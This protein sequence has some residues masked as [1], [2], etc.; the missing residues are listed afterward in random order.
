M[1][2][3]VKRGAFTLIEMVFV[4]VILGIVGMIGSDIIAKMYQGYLKSQIVNKLQQQ[5][6]LVLDIIS[7]RL[8]YRIKSSVIGRDSNSTNP[9]YLKYKALYDDNISSI[10]PDMIEWYGYDNESLRGDV[11]GSYSYPGWSGLV[12]VNSTKT[13]SSNGASGQ[14]YMP[15]SKLTFTKKVINFLSNN[16]VDNVNN[17][18]ILLSKCYHDS[19]MSIYGWDIPT[20]GANTFDNNATIKVSINGNDKLFSISDIGKR[21]FC[22]QYYLVWSAYALVPEGDNTNDFNLTLRYNYQ[23]WNGENYKD[24][25]NSTVLAEHVSTFRAMQVGNSVRVKICITDGNI[26]GT[27][28]GFCKEKAIY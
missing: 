4:I 25:A 20:L 9:N 6:E 2:K 1:K 22:E 18:A 28:Y 5:T 13:Y 3:M 23:P 27:P 21:D 7:S 17:K 11:N 26:T 24:D 15:G 14:I 8:K 16:K 12:D 19:N 10:S